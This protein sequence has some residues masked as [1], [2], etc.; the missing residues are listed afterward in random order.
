[1][2]VPREIQKMCFYWLYYEI[3][4]TKL[5]TWGFSK[6][7]LSLPVHEIIAK[8]CNSPC[9]ILYSV[10]I[11][12]LFYFGFVCVLL[13]CYFI[14]FFFGNHLC[15]SIFNDLGFANDSPWHCQ[16]VCVCVHTRVHV[17]VCMWE[18]AWVVGERGHFVQKHTSKTQTKLCVLEN[19]GYLSLF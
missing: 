13:L 14:P 3:C 15:E 17:C 2:C 7:T 16:N 8:R 11:M 5:F 4:S 1:M 10:W 6:N 9:H 12:R 19:T 18:C